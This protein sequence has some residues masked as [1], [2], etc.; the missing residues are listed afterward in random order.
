MARKLEIEYPGALYHIMH[1]GGNRESIFQDD[2]YREGLRKRAMGDK[3]KVAVVS[4]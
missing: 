3:G 2:R 1:R 4:G